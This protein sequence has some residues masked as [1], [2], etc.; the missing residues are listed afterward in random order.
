MTL[1][2]LVLLLKATYIF[3]QTF[4]IKYFIIFNCVMSMDLLQY[5]LHSEYSVL[6]EKF[7][8]IGLIWA[9]Y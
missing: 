6:Y 4:V 2:H 9:Y 7:H 1:R 5:Y 8:E 3:P